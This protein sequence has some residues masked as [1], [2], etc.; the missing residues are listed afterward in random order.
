MFG[1]TARERWAMAVA[2]VLAAVVLA[3]I[4]SNG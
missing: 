4:M 1:I 3:M 2:V